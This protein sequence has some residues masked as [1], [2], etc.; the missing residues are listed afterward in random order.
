M[1]ERRFRRARHRTVVEALRAMDRAFLEEVQCYFGGGTR[2]V[3]E[4][5]EYRESEDIDFL[6]SSR[7]GYRA[8]RSTVTDRSLGRIMAR[9]LPLA[10]EVRAD[11][12]GIR[13]FVDLGDSKLKLEIVQEGRIDVAGETVAGLPVPCLDRVSCFA[14]KYLANADR[15]GDA[16]MLARDVIDLAFMVAAWGEEPAKRGAAIA[17]QSYG[18]TVDEAARRAAEHL[19]QDDVARQRCVAALRVTG[20]ATL[21]KGLAKIAALA[22]PRGRRAATP[23]RRPGSR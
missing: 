13:T 18:A 23:R 5:G 21:A 4:L 19:L 22:G 12:Y 7:A 11:R 1:A 9:A 3:L 17:R 8:L 16:A 10:R 6:C 14:E 20:A 2:I 15:G